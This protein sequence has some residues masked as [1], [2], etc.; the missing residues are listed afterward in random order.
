MICVIGSNGFVGK[1]FCKFLI[2]KKQNFFGL[3][4]KNLNS[5]SYIKINLSNLKKL[6]KILN[7]KKPN[8]I[9]NLA[10]KVDFKKKK[11]L[12]CKINF[13]LPKFL[14]DY[15]A[16]KKIKFIQ[17]SGSIVHG[18]QFKSYSTNTPLKPDSNY[19]KNKLKADEYIQKKKKDYVIIRTGGIYGKGG[20]F[21]LG[22]NKS[23]SDGLKKIKP[24]LEGKGNF[25][26]NY[27][28]VND[29]CRFIYLTIKKNKKGVFYIGGEK[30][31]LKKIIKIISNKFTKGKYEHIKN[32][33]I[34]KNQII[35]N[36]ISFKYTSFKKT[37]DEVAVL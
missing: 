5:K 19:G 21:H 1:N 8:V 14:T 13:D 37:I 32:N 35:K 24:K 18:S 3:S 31:K 34:I 10:A 30:I 20:P 29:L 6:E 9:V 11:Y 33:K 27:I 28:Y 22:I 15:S 12:K 26:R 4:R 23:I 25:I 2:K 16:K 17:M 36:N 7:A